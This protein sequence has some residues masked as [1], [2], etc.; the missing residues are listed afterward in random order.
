MNWHLVTLQN[1]DHHYMRFGAIFDNVHTAIN[2]L[3]KIRKLMPER[4][5]ALLVEGDDQLTDIMPIEEEIYLIA[6]R[7]LKS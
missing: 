1:E 3:C 4:K 5:F 6:E 2:A 7:E